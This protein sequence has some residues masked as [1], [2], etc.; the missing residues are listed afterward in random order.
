VSGVDSMESYKW[1]YN[2]IILNLYLFCV[3]SLQRPELIE[4]DVLIDFKTREKEL[5]ERLDPSIRWYLVKRGVTI[6]ESV[7]VGF[8]TEFTRSGVEMN[9]IVSSQLAISCKTY[10]QIPRFERYKLSRLDELSNKLV[11][12]KKGSDSF[13]YNKVEVSIQHCIG[14]IRLVKYG[15][16][17]SSQLILVECFKIVNGVSYFEDD[18]YTIFGFPRTSI[19]P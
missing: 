18:E 19:Q 7:N 1:L 10:I 14:K 16:Y 4:E 5:F 17:D 15:N 9:R 11:K 12:L 8:D 6:K 13:N 3:V 2:L